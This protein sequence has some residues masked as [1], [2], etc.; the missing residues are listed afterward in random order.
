MSVHVCCV[1]VCVC[2][3]YM[4]CV[5]CVLCVCVCVCVCVCCVCVHTHTPAG[6]SDKGRWG[7][8]QMS[9]SYLATKAS[10]CGKGLPRLKQSVG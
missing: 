1:C 2:V 3:L 6:V 7:C 8:L 5:L 4:C 9:R 10:S